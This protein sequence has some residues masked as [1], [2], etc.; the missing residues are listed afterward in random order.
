VLTSLD[1]DTMA[2]QEVLDLYR[3]RWQ[4][5][6][7]FKRLKTLLHLGHL[8]KRS[9]A[10]ARA[11]IEG[12]PLTVLLIERLLDEARFF[13]PGDLT[14]CRR[15]HWREFREGRDSVL[16]VLGR[17]LYPSQLLRVA[18]RLGPLLANHERERPMWHQFARALLI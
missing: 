10:S 1:A 7:C 18:P 3:A 13:P 17:P 8:P 16:A 6:L 15:S 2:A 9:D 5:E 12:K 4:I 11:W 14:G